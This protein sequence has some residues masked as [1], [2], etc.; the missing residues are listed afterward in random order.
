M[1]LIVKLYSVQTIE[2]GDGIR[3]QLINSLGSVANLFTNLSVSKREG[4]VIS[5]PCPNGKNRRE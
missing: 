5:T 1:R 4:I 2:I 3:E